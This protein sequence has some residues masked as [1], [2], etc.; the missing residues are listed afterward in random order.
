LPESELT[1]TLYEKESVTFLDKAGK[2]ASDL[3]YFLIF[4]LPVFLVVFPVIAVIAVRSAIRRK[5]RKE[6]Q[7]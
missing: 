1:F 7:G 4:F 5:R 3:S 2:T 6:Q